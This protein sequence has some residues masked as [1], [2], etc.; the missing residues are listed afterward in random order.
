MVNFMLCVCAL[1]RVRLLV[2]PKTSQPAPLSTGV[3][4]GRILEWVATLSSR[5]SSQL[6]DRTQVSC[7]A[8]RFFTV[9]ATREAP[10]GNMCIIPQF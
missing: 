4:Q 9:G 2:T 3:L 7:T 5:G 8:G 1:S 6:R 10:C